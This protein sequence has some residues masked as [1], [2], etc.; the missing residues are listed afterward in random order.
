MSFLRAQVKEQF[1][2]CVESLGLKATI[3]GNETLPMKLDN[4]SSSLKVYL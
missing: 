3:L 1:Q 4:E 2:L